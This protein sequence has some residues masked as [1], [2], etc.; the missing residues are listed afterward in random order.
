MLKNYNTFAYD[1]NND[2]RKTHSVNN[3]NRF[4]PKNDRTFLPPK[5]SGVR[6]LSLDLP[7]KLFA[8]LLRYAQRRNIS[9]KAL[10]IQFIKEHLERD[11]QH[12]RKS[13]N[14]N[15]G[16]HS[17]NAKQQRNA[18]N[19]KKPLQEAVDINVPIYIEEE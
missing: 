19:V 12:Q 18:H 6:T 16:N 15:E 1:N 11:N 2:K 13:N 3:T 14:R 4:S 17:N 9:V 10:A 8:K 5:E 7:D